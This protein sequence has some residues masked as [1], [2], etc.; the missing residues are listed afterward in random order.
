MDRFELL[1]AIINGGVRG[2]TRVTWVEAELPK[3]S[4][5]C[6]ENGRRRV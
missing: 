2:S 1:T 3:R 4:Y 6:R 5:R